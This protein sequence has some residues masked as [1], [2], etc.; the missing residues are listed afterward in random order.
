M[1]TLP[2][3]TRATAS[4]IWSLCN[5]L[6]GD[7]ISY[8]QYIAELTYLLFLKV[9]EENGAES[10]LPEGYRWKD[11]VSYDGA[12]LLGHYQE[13]L[14]HLGTSSETKMVR[15][16]FAF[17]TTVFSHSENL[18]VV[19][20]GLNAIQWNQISEDGLGQIYEAL[21]AKNS[22][23]ARSGAGQYFTPRALVDC[24]VSIV[25][26]TVGELIQDPATGTGG[27]LISAD[28]YV[29]ATQTQEEYEATPPQYEGVEIER[30]TYRLC[31]MNVFLHRMNASL[32]LGDALTEDGSHLKPADVIIANPP[33]GAKSG[34]VRATRDSFSYSSSNKQLEFLQHIYQSLKPGG[35][36]AVVLPDNVLF[37][38]GVARMFSS[39]PVAMATKKIPRKSGFTTYEPPLLNSEKRIL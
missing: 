9:A 13:M 39:S 10:S 23:D 38:E 17:P 36:A 16:I 15:D 11:L 8:N 7:G 20:N 18:R 12:N 4:R 27:F 5:V 35:R 24:I 29:R 31:L 19:I 34:S 37:E 22:E 30:G 25:K 1:T 26:P 3:S 2:P 32:S 33:F 28:A 6:R 21:L 14:T